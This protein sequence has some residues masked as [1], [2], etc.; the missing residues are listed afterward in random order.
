LA[1]ACR[2]A[3]IEQLIDLLARFP[4]R[5]LFGN[6]WIVALGRE[7]FEEVL[8]RFRAFILASSPR[9]WIRQVRLPPGRQRKVWPMRT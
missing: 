7:L 3:G 6:D 2:W 4:F 8:L 9:L 1:I 5:Q